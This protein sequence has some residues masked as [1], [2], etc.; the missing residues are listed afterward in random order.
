[1]DDI[2]G[3]TGGGWAGRVKAERSSAFPAVDACLFSRVFPGG[4]GSASLLPSFEVLHYFISSPYKLFIWEIADA[5]Q[6]W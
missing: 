6:L 1:M 2:P 4:P 5:D 3:A